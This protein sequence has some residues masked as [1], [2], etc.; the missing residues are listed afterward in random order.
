[1][2]YSSSKILDSHSPRAQPAQPE[3]QLKHYNFRWREGK[4]SGCK[5]VGRVDALGHTQGDE[6]SDL[7]TQSVGLWD[8]V[9]PPVTSS[10]AAAVAYRLYSATDFTIKR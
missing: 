7:S 8:H 4:Q 6:S 2:K 9:R 1:M 5:Y 3:Y 10:R